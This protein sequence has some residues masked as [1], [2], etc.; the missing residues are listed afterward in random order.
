MKETAIV[1]PTSLTEEE[2]ALKVMFEKLR[3]IV[4][5][6]FHFFFCNFLEIYK[7]LCEVIKS[8]SIINI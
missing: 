8:N 2:K 6:N 3:A 4:S 5:Q 7:F 1:L